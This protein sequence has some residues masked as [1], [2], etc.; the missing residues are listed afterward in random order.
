MLPTELHKEISTVCFFWE[1]LKLCGSFQ[2]LHNLEKLQFP[3]L[4]KKRITIST[5]KIVVRVNPIIIICLHTIIL[6]LYLAHVKY[7]IGSRYWVNIMVIYSYYY[8]FCNTA[9]DITWVLIMNFLRDFQWLIKRKSWRKIFT[10]WKSF[11][12]IPLTVC[13]GYFS[14]LLF[15][16]FGMHFLFSKY[17]F[18][19]A[20]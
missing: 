3:H 6:L 9:N 5:S 7:W 20:T 16:G 14:W 8:Y 13:L 1:E 4:S 2:I 15:K 19:G 12:K 10:I 18:S 11:M 17:S